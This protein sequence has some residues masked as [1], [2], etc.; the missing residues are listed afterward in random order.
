MRRWWLPVA[1]AIGVLAVAAGAFWQYRRSQAVHA[2]VPA[3]SSPA[4]LVETEIA[5]NS[6]VQAAKVVNVPVPVDGTIEQFL[7][8]VGQHVSAGEVLARI[9][10]PKIALAL[11]AAQLD[12]EQARNHLS[13]LESEVIAARL[14]VSRS[15]ADAT[16]VKSELEQAEKT[17]ERQKMMYDQGVT[18]RLTYEKAEQEYNSLKAQSQNL[19]DVAK[20]AA[21]RVDS[22]TAELDPARKA[23]AQKTSDLEDAQAE[24][25]T[26]EV[27]APSD[28]V[29]IGRRG[30]PGEPVTTA[31]TDLFQI[32]TDPAALEVVGSVEPR[33]ADRI[34]AGQL[35]DIEI[36]GAP[37]ATTG[38]VREVK[39]GQVFVDLTSPSPAIKPGM[40][41]RVR[42]KLR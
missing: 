27:N 6:T 9:K 5:V 34:R 4:V 26:G 7:A 41:A 25:A 8:D 13:Q 29:L 32:S 19:V 33:L 2:K 16:R 3:A 18:P 39:A 21:D 30:K 31:V 42:I 40:T 35:A 15:E 11:Q 17:F 37:G 12:A 36:T 23:L 14:E 1:A 28:G 10:N 24:M 22:I 20:K 38:V